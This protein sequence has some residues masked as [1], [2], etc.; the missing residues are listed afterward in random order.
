[1]V[2]QSG[3]GKNSF[4]YTGP[5]IFGSDIVEVV[6]STKDNA[7]YASNRVTISTTDPEIIFYEENDL[8]GTNYTKVIPTTF[9]MQTEEF[10]LRAEPCYFT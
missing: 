2:L 8:F 3:Y 5:K 4:S 1:V 10:K 6:V 7:V 9:S